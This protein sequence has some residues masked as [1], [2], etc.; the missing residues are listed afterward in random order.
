LVLF[1]PDGTGVDWIVHR[2]PFQ[3]MASGM[4]ASASASLPTNPT[5]VHAV[6]DAHD[7]AL[8]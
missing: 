7:T 5:A 1:V 8:R 6:R 3:D 2:A 4:F